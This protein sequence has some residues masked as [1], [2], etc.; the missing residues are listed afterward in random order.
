M[1]VRNGENY[2]SYSPCGH[3]LCTDCEIKWFDVAIGPPI[4]DPILGGGGGGGRGT[5]VFG[6]GEEER[7]EREGGV[8]GRR[9][10]EGGEWERSSQ[11]CGHHQPDD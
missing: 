3:K 4:L 2:C 6:L 5:G 1:K 9:L 7:K 8:Q 11:G 10:F